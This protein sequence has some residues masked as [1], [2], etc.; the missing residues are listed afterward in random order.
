[1]L[2]TDRVTPLVPE[3]LNEIAFFNP[4]LSRCYALSLSLNYLIEGVALVC[5]FFISPQLH[6]ARRR[7][8]FIVSNIFLFF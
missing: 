4:T 8:I 1:M 7:K 3:Y 6:L 5:F 2:V